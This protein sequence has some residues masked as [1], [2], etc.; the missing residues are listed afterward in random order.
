MELKGLL[1]N[2][3]QKENNFEKRKEKL[4]LCIANAAAAINAGEQK[5]EQGSAAA[6]RSFIGRFFFHHEFPPLN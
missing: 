1:S 6:D 2:F 3:G 4:C 5:M